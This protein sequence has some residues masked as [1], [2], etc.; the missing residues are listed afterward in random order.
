MVCIV[1]LRWNIDVDVKIKTRCRPAAQLRALEAELVAR[2][3]L[4]AEGGV[5]LHTNVHSG[6]D[7]WPEQDQAEY[8]KHALPMLASNRCSGDNGDNGDNGADASASSHET[9]RGRPLGNPFVAARLCHQFPELKLTLDASHWMLVCERLLGSPGS[10]A[11]AE[12]TNALSMLL[13]RTAHIHARVGTV[14]AA[15]LG[16]G[17]AGYTEFEKAA[18]DAHE[19]LWLKVWEHQRLA[20]TLDVTTATPE[21]GPTPYTPFVPTTDTPVANVWD[22]TEEAARRLKAL[23]ASATPN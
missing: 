5:L 2:D 1:I 20:G 8:F 15:Q 18:V 9:H 4:N 22:Q 7:G 11:N 6:S 23:F 12:E 19:E 10:S 21:Y 14:E 17:A 13:Q 3:Q 16:S